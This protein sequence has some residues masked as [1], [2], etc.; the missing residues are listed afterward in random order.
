MG[1]EEENSVDPKHYISRVIDEAKSR[2][3]EIDAGDSLGDNTF[4]GVETTDTF[5][6][7]ERVN[8]HQVDSNRYQT[9]ISKSVRAVFSG[10]QLD[11]DCAI[12]IDQETPA[13]GTVVGVVL[14]GEDV[15]KSNGSKYVRK[16]STNE[17]QGTHTVT[18][19]QDVVSEFASDET[20]Q[21]VP[22]CVYVADGA[23]AFQR[24]QT[25]D[26]SVRRDCH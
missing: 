11:Q 24:P 8:L 20:Q 23:I 3:G 14:S 4:S 21:K 2:I 12:Y 22:V 13:S 15:P 10:Q 26:V 9:H 17:G 25:V 6:P 1:S 18:L 16:V 19:H 7:V 5:R